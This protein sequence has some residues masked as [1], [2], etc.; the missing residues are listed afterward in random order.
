[1]V[2]EKIQGI[3]RLKI[4]AAGIRLEV[5]V[6][7]ADLVCQSAEPGAK[8]GAEFQS[9]EVYLSEVGR[10][11][12]AAAV[13]ADPVNQVGALSVKKSGLRLEPAMSKFRA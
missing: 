11:R 2:P 3:I 13:E 12:L 1:L 9:A 4:L 8:L 10:L 7:K 6:T 5:T